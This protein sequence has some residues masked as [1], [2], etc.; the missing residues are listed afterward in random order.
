[1][2]NLT[3]RNSARQPVWGRTQV[4]PAIALTLT[5][6]FGLLLGTSQAVA[7]L[8]IGLTENLSLTHDS[9]I[10]T[11]DVLRPSIAGG[12]KARPLVVDLHGASSNG[13][14]QRG[15]SNWNSI[16]EANGFY[17]AWPDGLFN[18]W[19]GITCCGTAVT[20]DVDDVGFIRAMVAAISAEVNINQTRIYVTGLSNGSA[21]T[22][23]LACEAADLFAAAAPMAFP[24]PHVDFGLDCNPSESIPVLSFMGLTDVLVPYSGA[25][26][27]LVD[28]RDKNSCDAAGNPTEISETYGGSDCVIDTSCGDPGI[29]VGLC[30]VRGTAFDPPGDVFSGHILYI[31]DDAFDISQRAWEFMSVYGTPSESVP[32]LSS[33]LLLIGIIAAAGGVVIRRRQSRK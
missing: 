30:S 2:M 25:A 11:Y 33:P 17:V 10:R 9:E 7:D 15:L 26:P 18:T 28:W 19:N 4:G 8:P 16:A 6:L 20:N 5:L 22:Q 27:S 14:G 21:M 12:L 13:N 29:E 31:N 23:R 32:A 3:R 24:T 1:M